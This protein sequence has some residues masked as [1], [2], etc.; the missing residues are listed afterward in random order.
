MPM[1]SKA[2]HITGFRAVALALLPMALGLAGAVF[3]ERTRLGFSTWRAAC[4]AAGV[5]LVSLV[6]FTLQLMPTAVLAALAGG[7]A[8]Q[9]SGLLQ[10]HRPGALAAA[11]AAHGG[12]ALG[13]SA[14]LILCAFALPMAVPVPWLLGIEM[15]LTALGAWSLL[16]LLERR[17]LRRAAATAATSELAS[18]S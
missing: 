5:S 18:A 2:S 12:C 1:N 15:I 4:R 17:H 11:T 9:A 10:R 8:I 7:L 16:A 3:D 14:G 6:A 13:M